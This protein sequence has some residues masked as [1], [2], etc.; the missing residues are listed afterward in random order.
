MSQKIQEAEDL[1][2]AA[3]ALAD[4]LLIVVIIAIIVAILFSIVIAVYISGLICK[5]LKPLERYMVEAGNTGKVS[6]TAQEI[7]DFDKFSKGDDEIAH[8]ISACKKFL[9]HIQEIN[10]DMSKISEGDLTVKVHSKSANDELG[11]YLSSLGGKFNESLGEINTCADQVKDASIQI[12]DGAQSLAQ[13]STEQAASVE[14]LSSSI[15]EMST[16]I[17]G[18]ADMAGECAS[19]S[20]D[21]KG[22]AEK[23]ST[24]MDGLMGAVRDITEASNQIEK[25][26]KVIDDIA[27]QT[28]ILA[29]NAA[30]EAARAG[31]AGKGFAVVAEEVRNLASKSAEAAKNTSGLIENSITKANLGLNLA[32]ETAASLTEIVDGI[33]Q[34][35][36]IISQIADSSEHQS[37]AISQLNIGVEQIANVIQQNSATA[38]QSAAASEEMNGQTNMLKDLVAQ[39]KTD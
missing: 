16:Q 22:K 12:A 1:N 35:A 9:E 14:E 17:K 24:Q 26:I 3:E 6:L 15:Q 5:P 36:D 19:L 30:V 4:T 28:N 18:T 11:K 20:G 8:T 21:I 39:F 27:F 10:E 25:V 34:S 37:V 29:L 31:S 32:T 38:E 2:Y 33:N 23:V 13:A 7:T